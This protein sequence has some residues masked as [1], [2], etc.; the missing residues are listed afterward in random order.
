[1]SQTIARLPDELA[2]LDRAARQVRRTRGCI[3][4]FNGKLRDE[5]LNEHW[6]EMLI[7]PGAR[8]MQLDPLLTPR[9]SIKLATPDFL[10]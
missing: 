6:F 8:A 10:N 2:E 7:R 4:R 3:E 5:F 9:R 1:M